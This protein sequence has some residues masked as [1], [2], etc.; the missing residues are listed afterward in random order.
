MHWFQGYLQSGI[1]FPSFIKSDHFA[2]SPNSNGAPKQDI[3]FTYR[4][5]KIF[6]KI[7]MDTIITGIGIFLLLGLVGI[8]RQ[9]L[10]RSQ[11]NKNTQEQKLHDFKKEKA[12][13]NLRIARKN[14][15]QKKTVCNA[16]EQ[17]A[18]A[19][20]WDVVRARQ[21]KERVLPQVSLGEIIMHPNGRIHAA[22][23]SKRVDLL[24]TDAQFNPLVVIEIDGSGHY[25]SNYSRIN[26]ETKTLAL[27]SAG[28]P[29]LRIAAKHDNHAE[30]RRMVRKG[31]EQFFAG[32][33]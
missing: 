9:R 25:L 13:E 29:L 22:I 18:Y 6:V 15:Y 8:G 4:Q 23:N 2:A 33:K 20:A 30:I 21:R 10:R 12:E 28:I 7:N 14:R 24:V 16:N 31:L 3:Q 1:I 27:R 26:D 19:A 17:A 5:Q 32:R 11:K